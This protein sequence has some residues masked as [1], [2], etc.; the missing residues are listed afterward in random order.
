VTTN[1]PATIS[2]ILATQGRPHLGVTAATTAAQLDHGDELLIVRQ[3]TPWGNQARNQAIPRCKGD[4]LMFV[5][6]D[7]VHTDHAINI[8][9]SA[10]RQNPDR[11]HLF[12]M[13]YQH[14]RRTLYPELPLQPG[15]VGTPMMVIPNTPGLVGEWSDRY[16]GDYD[17]LAE[18]MRLRGD[19][20]VLHDDVIALIGDPA[21]V[22]LEAV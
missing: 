3:N 7:D 14:D 6:D 11:V 12:A 19:T 10:L 13:R 18:T 2:V 17:F 16:E 5:D 15:R 4:Y 8:V 1:N 20:P 9:R 22:R 21:H